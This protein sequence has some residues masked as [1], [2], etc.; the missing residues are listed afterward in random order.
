MTPTQKPK[1]KRGGRRERLAQRAAKPVTDPC[2]PGQIGGAYRP[3]SERNIE[4]IYQTSL[5][6]LAELGMSEV[7]KNLSEKLLAAGA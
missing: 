2:P 1:P 4:D 3:L 5:R 7:P 6:L